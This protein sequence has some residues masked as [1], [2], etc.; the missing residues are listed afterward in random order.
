[1]R[2]SLNWI[3]DYVDI[4]NENK[5]ELADKITNA[6]VNVEKIEEHNFDKLVVGYVTDRKD[7]PDSDHLNVC[8]VDIGTET[9]QIVCGAPNVDKGQKVVVSLIGAIL[10]GDFEIKERT[11]RGITSYGMICSLKELGIGEEASGI[12][13]L[14]DDAVAGDN[15]LKYLGLDD[16]IYHL[17]LNPNRGDC[18]SHIGFAYEV[19]GVTGK[20]ITLPNIN[21]NEI[22]D[23]INKYFSLEVETDK[24][25]F[26]S[27]RMVKDVKIG[28]SPDFIKH[29]LEAAGMRSI[30]NVVDISN[31]IMLEYGQPLH[32]FDK[33]KLGDKIVVK[34]AKENETV[35]TLDD[36]ERKLKAEDI[37]ITDG[38]KVVCIAGV[39]GAKNTDVDLDTKNILI[40]SAIFNPVSIR[41][42]SGNLGLRSEAS[43]RYEKGLNYEYT[44]MAL[45][46]GV[47]LLEEYAS[48]IVLKDKVVFDKIEKTK[49]IINISL[50]KINTVLGIEISKE[51]INNIFNQL[52]FEFTY[53]N[54]TY[55]VTV[56]SR[57]LD[58]S[59]PEDLIEEIGRIY[60][61]DKLKDSLPI[62]SLKPG[63]Y[64]PF[65]KFRKDISKR[66]RALS[67]DEVKTYTLV[68]QQD[69]AFDDN[70]NIKLNLPMSNDR[71]LIRTSII[72]SLIKTY[73]YNKARNIENINIYE[74]ANV[75]YEDF[76]EET[77][78]AILMSKKHIAD[79][80]QNNEKNTDFYVLKGIIE[81]LLNYLGYDNR[82]NFTVN[83]NIKELHPGV[84][85]SIFIDK[86]KIGFVGK[87]HPIYNK[88]E[89]YVA[90]ISLNKM[91]EKKPKKLKYP[92][93]S[94][95]PEII[96]DVAF[97]L[98]QDINYGDILKEIKKIASKILTDIKVFDLYV[99]ENI[100]SDK[101]SLA[102]SLTFQ[103]ASKTLTEEEVDTIF[104]KI[105][106]KIKATFNCEIR[107]K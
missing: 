85:A 73:E 41:Y 18:L 32:F 8:T 98:D 96:K 53:K 75:Y 76:T 62:T 37:V 72:P 7:H 104:R 93:I 6:G 67:L 16:V 57:C 86:E 59:I 58:I 81:N 107:D 102:I 45:D 34:M 26:Y 94:K 25:S 60:G 71:S 5:K 106:D 47:S 77:K 35:L 11:V 36:Q 13:V 91:Y 30:N 79:N 95:Y 2:I 64:A 51:E 12:H 89:I 69:L 66:L 54:D 97:V 88:D 14:N 10:P 56:P 9:L 55:S 68:G 31:Y 78:V 83:E 48:G 99:G 46:R 82:V 90:E 42:T 65:T 21:I 20:K 103:D 44:L 43:T 63:A 40:E 100:A 105:I 101:K 38:K 70:K 33:D 84:S 17:D 52:G 19:A 49:K 50:N 87:I 22:D 15:P 3:N 92:E 28:P 4:K 24:C 39:M 27:A 74:I 1:M 80:W 29:R 61:Y 23:S